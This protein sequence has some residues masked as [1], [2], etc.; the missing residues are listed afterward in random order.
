MENMVVLS[1]MAATMFVNAFSH[2]SPGLMT[3]AEYGAASA[4]VRSQITA[5]KNK[6][7]TFCVAARPY[8]APP[9]ELLNY[10]RN[11]G[12]KVLSRPACLKRG[13]IEID[14][15]KLD[16]TSAGDLFIT[17]RVV[18]LTD[19]AAHVGVRLRFGVYHLKKDGGRWRILD[20]KDLGETP[21]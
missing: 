20:Y 4:V 11:H 2:D 17:A 16:R 12:L 10:L 1:L 9:T 21:D 19:T 6:G 5:F 14:F 7:P 15:S 3:M 18:D 13:G 8:D